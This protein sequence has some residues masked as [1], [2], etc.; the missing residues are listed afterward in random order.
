LRLGHIQKGA[1]RKTAFGGLLPASPAAASDDL[2]FEV[3]PDDMKQ[4]MSVLFS[5]AASAQKNLRLTE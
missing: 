3:K 5:K 1:S 2:F 4:A